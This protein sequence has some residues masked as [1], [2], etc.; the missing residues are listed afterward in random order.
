MSKELKPERYMQTTRQCQRG[1]CL[2]RGW[3]SPSPRPILPHWPRLGSAGCPQ[4]ISL[5][6][7][8][9]SWDPDNA[10]DYTLPFFVRAL[11]SIDNV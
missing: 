7:Y 5:T 9:H 2:G 8:S 6:M 11:P 10:R 1:L 3:Q 4:V